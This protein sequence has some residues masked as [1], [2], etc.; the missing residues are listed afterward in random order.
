MELDL[1]FLTLPNHVVCNSDFQSDIFTI[2]VGPSEKAFTAHQDTLAQS[3]VLNKHCSGGFQEQHTKI[4]NLPDV[5]PKIFALLLEYLYR[6]DYW[7]KCGEE[8]TKAHS[9][10]RDVRATQM[11]REGN[12]YCLA[13]YFQ[14]EQ[15]QRLAVQKMQML[16]PL[17][18][19]SFLSVSEVIYSESGPGPF[20]EYF[21]QQ[22]E[23][24][25]PEVAD[26]PWILQRIAN[27]GDFA[28]ELFS[29]S[30][31]PSSRNDGKP[32]EMVTVTWPRKERSS[33]APF[34]AP[35]P[36]LTRVSHPFGLSS[37]TQPPAPFR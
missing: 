23:G 34:R 6:G 7:P 14:L 25:L 4:I 33:L 28:T 15:L 5:D 13:E 20:R 2:V 27:G 29:C 21:R 10:D 17:T 8:F 31:K 1:S 37:T 9:E 16:T 19:E 3:A 24:P 18:F 36:E 32:K 22:I 26:E 11:Q 30:H 35:Q 12:I